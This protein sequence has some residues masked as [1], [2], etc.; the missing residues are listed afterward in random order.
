MQD[1]PVCLEGVRNM[2][3]AC[4]GA[5]A[6]DRLLILREDP[7]HGY[8]GRGLDGVI[9]RGAEML[10]LLVTIRDVP[11]YRE[12]DALPL[13]LERAFQNADHALFLARLGDQIRFLQQPGGARAVVSYILDTD[14][15]GSAFATAPHEAFVALKAAF[16]GLFS[17][18]EQVHVT[19]ARGTD[20]RGRPPGA[21]GARPDVGVK[22]FPMSVFAPIDAAGFSGRIAVAHF[23]VG[24]G[25]R[26]YS[27]YG[28]PL[29]DTVFAEISGGLTQAWHGPAAVTSYVRAHYAAVADRY[30]I[31]ADAVHSWHAGIHP[32]CAYRQPAAANFERWSGSAFGNPRLLHVHTCGAY[33]PGEICW[34]IVDP[35]VTVDGRPV[36]RAGRIDLDAVPGAMQIVRGYPDVARLFAAPVRDIGID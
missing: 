16:D 35:T 32:A 10:G 26:Y 30:G 13:E 29:A 7:A 36:W 12:V 6:G 19:C 15:I 5:R 20:I 2:L 18:A 28:V 1:E 25:S 22:R 33:A 4:A 34:N 8:Y 23:L 27:P 21:P 17:G 11:L 24:T 9:A 14:M 31:E 3:V